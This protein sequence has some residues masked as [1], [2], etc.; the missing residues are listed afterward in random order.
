MEK[1]IQNKNSDAAFGT[2]FRISMYFQSIKQNPCIFFLF[3]KAAI[4]VINHLRMYREN[5]LK[6]TRL[7]EKYS[8][9]DQVHLTIRYRYL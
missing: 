2:T 5:L 6:F 9:R 4:I 8:S 1:E 3:N 7:Q